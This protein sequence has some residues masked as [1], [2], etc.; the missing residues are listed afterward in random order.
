MASI[1]KDANIFREISSIRIFVRVY[2][3]IVRKE[4][5]KKQI[6]GGTNVLVRKKRMTKR[7]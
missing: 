5:K 3:R 1:T 2:T 4:G 6:D 7:G